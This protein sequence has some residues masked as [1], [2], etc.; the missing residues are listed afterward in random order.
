MAGNRTVLAAVHNHLGDNLKCSCGVGITHWESR[1]GEA[2]ASLPGAKPEMF[3]APSQILKRN[4][5]L[6]P[7]VYQQRIAEATA[8]FF[9]AV[10]NWVTIDE[11]PFSQVTDV[12]HTVLEGP[13]ADRAYVVTG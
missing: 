6:G 10:D 3:F 1:D 2:P 9:G 7:A 4:E 11:S 5:E 13:A 12:Y 8:A